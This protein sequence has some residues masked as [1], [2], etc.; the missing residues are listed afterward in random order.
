MRSM[1]YVTASRWRSLCKALGL[2]DSDGEYDKLIGAWRSWGRHYHTLD[3]LAACLQELDRS[4]DFAEHPGEVELAL[5]F[6][7]AIY[8]TYRTDNERRSAEWAARF[9]AAHA[10]TPETVSRVRRLVLATA[11]TAN[12]PAGDMALVVD[13]DLS[14]L[15]Q[16]ESIYDRFESDVRREYWWVP[17]R[18]YS[19]ARVHILQSFLAR[20]SIYHWP[21]FRERYEVSAR[22]NLQR[23]ISRL[24][25]P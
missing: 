15:G 6:H 19:S 16:S 11:H 25:S 10:A 20:P 5:W 18:R 23:A 2:A 13:I 1:E 7:D 14:I 24:G 8:R 3:H 12:E 22:E 17:R 9:T 4:R 21:Y